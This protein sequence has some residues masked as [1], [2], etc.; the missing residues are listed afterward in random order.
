LLG[1][2]EDIYMQTGGPFMLKP[3]N[4][5]FQTAILL[6]TLCG[7]ADGQTSATLPPVAPTSNTLAPLPELN[8]AILVPV[9]QLEG[10]QFVEG[11]TSQLLLEKDGKRYLIDTQTQ[12]I[13]QLNTKAVEVAQG[14]STASTSPQTS[15]T[16]TP[17]ATKTE[18]QETETYYT[19]DI[20][21]W[22]L[23]TAHHLEKK[24]LMVDFTHR[25]NFNEVFEPGAISDFLGLDGFSFS[26]L[27]LTYGITDRFFAGIYRTP[28]SIGRI[29][30][31]SAGA[32]LSRENLGHPF[33][34]TFRVGVEG[35]DHFRSKYITSLELAFA[36]SLKKRAQI[37]FAPTISFNNRPLQVVANDVFN[38]TPVDGKTTV[39]LGAGIS[40][41]IRPTVAIVGEAIYRVSGWLEQ[42]AAGFPTARRPSFMLGIQKKIYRH[43]FTLGVTN[44]PGTTLSTRS[45]T[46][47]AYGLDDTFSGLTLGFN[48]SRRL[49]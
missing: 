25:F 2:E 22:N 6:F 32:Q 43:S 35:T 47:G 27:G 40:V 3:F 45:A 13:K 11:S 38:Q 10:L 37:Y 39:A 42:T 34:S 15:Q 7:S 31:L 28:T 12:T 1:Q 5:L 29:I 49:F 21:L 24:A 16:T 46:R 9:P 4:R 18:D 48:L 41:D 19:E 8:Q 33:S 36:R 44:S 30:Q 23:P 26:S 20:V 14:A 17:P